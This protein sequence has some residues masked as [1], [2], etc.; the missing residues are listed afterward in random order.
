MASSFAKGGE[1][2]MA[3]DP[4]CGME[5]DEQRAARQNEHQGRTYY[6]C[7]L[8]CQQRFTERRDGTYVSR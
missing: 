4:V 5:V 6:F 8:G 2:I 1:P 7:S 3:K